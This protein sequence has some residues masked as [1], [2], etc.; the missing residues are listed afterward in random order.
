MAVVRCPACRGASRVDDAALGLTVLCPRCGETFVALSEA[1]LVAP[2][3]PTD[4]GGRATGIAPRDL[5]DDVF[6]PDNED[7]DE[8]EDEEEPEEDEPGHAPAVPSEEDHDPHRD[9]PGGLPTSV[10]IGLALL[11]FA[12]PILWLIAPAIVG[13]PPS[14]T[15]A[16]PVALAVTASILCLA[17]IYTVD[18]SPGTRVKGV[19]T[20]VGLAYFTGVGLYV[21]DK[22]MVERFRKALGLSEEWHEFRPP[23][24][25]YQVA[26]PA[27]AEACQDQPFP[28][29]PFT[30]EC[31]RAVRDGAFTRQV[32]VVGFAP[33]PGPIP[34]RDDWFKDVTAALAKQP[35]V[36]AL[37]IRHDGLDGREL[38]V[39]H[40]GNNRVIR[41]LLGKHRAYYLSAEGPGLS[42]EDQLVQAFFGSFRPA[43]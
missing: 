7:E 22:D 42:Q 4:G 43:E 20:L 14:M 33:L 17:V 2:A 24:A 16:A 9:P 29:P 25:E 26:V 27:V 13:R 15:V 34:N 28:R 19:L 1:E 5:A 6:P 21:L 12:V 40:N 39:R 31:Y 18:W 10:L 30:S 38:V 8:D 11:P 37:A 35:R 32:F 3:A 41:I 36:W 23:G